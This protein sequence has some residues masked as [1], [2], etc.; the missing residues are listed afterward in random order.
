MR[1]V[2]LAGLVAA[3]VCGTRE[4]AAQHALPPGFD[5]PVVFSGLTLPTGVRFSPDGRIFVAE[6]SGIIKVF[7]GL[8]DPTPTVVANLSTNV[9]DFWDRGMLGLA[10]HPDFPTTPYVYVLYAYDFDPATPAIGPPRWGDQCPGSPGGPGPTTDGCVVNGRLSRLHVSPTNTQ[11][12]GETVLLENNWCQQFPSHSVGSLNF[13]P[14]GALYLQAGDG[15]SFNVADYGQLGGTIGSFTP[16]N[17]CGDPPGGRGGAMSA[18]TA[19]GGALRSQ[20]LRT[21]ADTAVTFD[22][23]VLRVD[24]ITG[25]AWPDNPLVGGA[26]PN[27]DRIIAHGFRNPFR[28]TIRPGTSELWVGDVGWNVWEEINRL[29][30]PLGGVENFG[31]P[32]YEGAPRQGGYD[33][34]NLNICENLYAAGAGAVVAP[35]YAYDHAQDVNPSGDGC[36]TGT[37]SISG[38]AFYLPGVYPS[39]YDDALFFADYSRDCIY[40]MRKGT[41]GLP[42]LA[43]RTA[44]VVDAFNPVDLQRGPG[45]DLYY[46]DFDGGN[47]R[48]IRYSVGNTPPTAVAQATPTSGPTPLLVQF[49]GSGSTDPDPGATLF[50]AWDLDGDGEYDDSTI[51]NPTRSYAAEA[52]IDVGLRVTDDDGASDTDT[53]VITPG[54]TAPVP[55]ISSPLVDPPWRVGDLIPYAATADDAED[56]QLPAS[57]FHWEILMH[58]CPGGPGDCHAHVVEHHDGITGGSFQTPDHEWYSYLE[59]KLRVEDSDGLEGTAAVSVQPAT[60]AN[61]Y[62]SSPSGMK[63]VLGGIEQ[64]APFG[65]DAIVGSTNSISAPSPQTLG[66]TTYYWTGWSDGGAQSH[67]FVAT[68]TPVTR[69]ATFAPCVAADACDGLDNDCNGVPDDPPPPGAVSSLTL[70]R[71]TVDWA[72]RPD[73]TGYD[74]VRG[75]LSA[76]RDSSGSFSTATGACLGNDV[77]ASSVGDPTDPPPNEGFWFL[78]R[79]VNCTGVGTYDT[80]ARDTGI[81]ASAQNCPSADVESPTA[82]SNL[83]AGSLPGLVTLTWDSSTDNVGV[84]LYGVHRSTT[85]GFTPAVGNRIALTAATLYRDT[86]FAAGTYH[87]LVVAQDA[88]GNGSPPSG[89]RSVTVAADTSAPQVTIT[90]PTPNAQVTETVAVT[91]VAVDDVGVTGVQ[92]QLDGAPLGPEDTVAPYATSWDTTSAADGAHTLTAIARDARDNLA[93]ATVDVSKGPPPGLVGAWSFNAS[94]P[95][96]IDGSGHGNNGAISGATWT[97]SGKFGGA[98]SFDGVND[99]VTVADAASLDLTTGMTLEAWVNPSTSLSFWVSVIDKDVDRYYLMASSNGPN[100]PAVG[101]TWGPNNPLVTAPSTLAP[102]VWTHLAATFDGSVIRLYVNGDL[103]GSV[104]ETNPISTSSDVLQIGA[105]FYGE[106][107]PGRIDEVRVYDRALLETEI[108]TDMVTPLP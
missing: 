62:A 81:G 37:S 24:P 39:I 82:P 31:W 4:A 29:T 25:A 56:G 106:Y 47:I 63:T 33:N 19:E 69:T 105:N 7:D 36:R 52:T 15:A 59:F 91:A 44:F 94:G 72:P 102:N 21:S 83:A 40:V 46:A 16:R 98:L 100:T 80:A 6:K 35:Y 43:T 12:G 77:A 70:A 2:V 79:A 74:V 88:A 5:D 58:H 76:L 61:G 53:I 11:I 85:P 84:T 49:D 55:T 101:G 97:A 71:P 104:A 87:Y 14:E 48:R 92:F 27:D 34:L 65:K 32:C 1:T 90:A 86:G 73:A 89:E 64:V 78:T 9:H 66:A 103:A 23:A 17:P 20:D 42:D 67:A 93:T 96:A 3:S 50:Y 28:A 8:S 60:V 108:E 57:A 99:R 10:L 51:V 30:D 54:S 41:D 68:D 45:G 75:S 22:G 38:L 107:F 13:G 95:T 26:N 18:P